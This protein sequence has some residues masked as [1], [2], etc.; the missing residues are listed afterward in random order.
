[1][2]SEEIEYIVIAKRVRGPIILMD[3]RDFT[4]NSSGWMI[5]PPPE[6]SPAAEQLQ[7]V[8][9]DEETKDSLPDT[10][11]SEYEDDLVDLELRNRVQK[12]TAAQIKWI[13]KHL[14][15]GR[16][17]RDVGE[18]QHDVVDKLNTISQMAGLPKYFSHNGLD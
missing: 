12:A 11:E 9:R 18:I 15:S 2:G 4:I 10:T 3:I 8:L 13:K 5:L 1:V 17:F 16:M 6:I 14:Y 7:Q